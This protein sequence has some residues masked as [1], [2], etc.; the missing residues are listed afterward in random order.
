MQNF[1][2]DSLGGAGQVHIAPSQQYRGGGN[3]K[4]YNFL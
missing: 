4:F 3:G 2:Q 1:Q